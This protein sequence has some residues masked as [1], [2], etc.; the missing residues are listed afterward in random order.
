MGIYICFPDINSARSFVGQNKW[1]SLFYNESKLS[2]ECDG[3]KNIPAINYSYH[4]TCF[5]DIFKCDNW[6]LVFDAQQR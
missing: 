1:L 5:A 3:D 4:G 2:V 6:M